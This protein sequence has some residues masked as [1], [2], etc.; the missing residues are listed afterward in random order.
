MKKENE[1]HYVPNWV[2]YTPKP[3]KISEDKLK[4]RVKTR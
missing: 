1:V 4:S 2:F 3:I